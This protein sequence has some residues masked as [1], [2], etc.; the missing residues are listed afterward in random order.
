VRSTQQQR[1]RHDGWF[2]VIAGKS[3][4]TGGAAKCFAFVQIYDTKP[5][6]RQF[7]VLRS[8]GTAMN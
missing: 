6:R 7:E 2:E 1:S 5:K 4:P 8:Q 3:M